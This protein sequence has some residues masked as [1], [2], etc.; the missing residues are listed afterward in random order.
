[1]GWFKKTALNLILN[2]DESKINKSRIFRELSEIED[3]KRDI[4][5]WY[6]LKISR[7]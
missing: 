3:V 4:E 7:V 1:V 2:I 5:K 6:P